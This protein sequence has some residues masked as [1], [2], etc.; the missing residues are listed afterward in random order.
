M[1][2]NYISSGNYKFKKKKKKN[3]NLGN[4]L[5]LFCINLFKVLKIAWTMWSVVQIEPEPHTTKCIWLFT[6]RIF[7]IWKLTS[8]A[9]HVNSV[10]SGY[11]VR[12]IHADCRNYSPWLIM[13]FEVWHWKKK[14][15]LLWLVQAS[16]W[17]SPPILRVYGQ[18]QFAY[19]MLESRN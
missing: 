19:K 9:C 18:S 15:K 4:T 7:R 6:D 3:R 5:F 13:G 10:E 2:L 17:L 16:R 1:L 11:G 8:S 12:A 14:K